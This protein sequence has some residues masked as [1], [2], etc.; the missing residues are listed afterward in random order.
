MFPIP[1]TTSWRISNCPIAIVD[2][3][4]TS[5]ARPGRAPARSGSG[6]IPAIV[7]SFSAGLC[8][9]QTD[10]PLRSPRCV[11]LASRSRTRGEAPEEDEEGRPIPPRNGP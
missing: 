1:P 7:A 8:N 6:P 10:G 5:Q 9:A 3:P 11:S 4:I 2:A